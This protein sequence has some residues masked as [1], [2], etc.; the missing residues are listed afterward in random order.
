[1][2]LSSLYQLIIS[3]IVYSNRMVTH[4]LLITDNLLKLYFLKLFSVLSKILHYCYFYFFK[5]TDL[6]F[7]NF[8]D[9]HMQFF[10]FYIVILLFGFYDL[11][12]FWPFKIQTET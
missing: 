6:F 10:F 11:H 4:R 3:G 5:F 9:T 7:Y 12:G 8:I 2:N 1:M